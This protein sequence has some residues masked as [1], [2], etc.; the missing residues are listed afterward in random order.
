MFLN[1][2]SS[3]YVRILFGVPQGSILGPLLF[4]IFINDIIE[5]IR[6][7]IFLFADDTSLI[8]IGSNWL[9]VQDVLNDDLGKLSVRS[10]MWL[11][12]FN[13]SKTEY[14]QISN[15]PNSV[16]P[17]V[18]KLNDELLTRVETHKHLG[19]VLNCN[20]TWS[21]HIDNICKRVNIR[22][23]MM[24]KL[25]GLLHR[26]SL[27]K[28]YCSWVRPVLEYCSVCYDN[29]S[30]G[31]SNRL[32]GLQRRALLI[33]TGAQFRT[34]TIK[35]LDE[36]GVSTLRARRLVAKLILFFKVKTGLTPTYLYD[37]MTSLNIVSSRP[38]SN[39]L[40]IPRCRTAKYKNSF[41]PSVVVSWN[42][43]SNC[44]KLETL[45]LAQFK[46]SL[47]VKYGINRG[48]M[49]NSLHG[50]YSVLLT[51]IRLGLSKLRGDL[52]TFN[53]TENPI[54]PLCLNAFECAQ[55]FLF[56]CTSLIIQRNEW[57]S[58]LR[59]VV[60]DI[61]LSD[62]IYLMKLCIFGSVNFSNDVNLAI[63][64]LTIEFIRASNRFSPLYLIDK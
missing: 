16:S 21:D 19:L 3:E 42:N 45:S 38:N 25:K 31:E 51:Q 30:I 56:S 9:D 15:K 53:L 36:V 12:T 47:F 52:F 13:A 24:R 8:N 46:K 33:V 14:M 4:L 35:L 40:I 55:H 20:F 58:K 48:Q 62:S 17:I 57:M 39:R 63:L 11:L 6:S 41:F 7:E 23:A 1:G 32:E 43:L 54:C 50:F 18:L 2:K 26:S 5:D 27:M 22:L 34:E 61:D 37:L 64:R 29:L 60:H 49:F 59:M 10:K 44:D 28:L